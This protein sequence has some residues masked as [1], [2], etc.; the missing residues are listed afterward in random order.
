MTSNLTWRHTDGLVV[1]DLWVTPVGIASPQLPHIKEGLPVDE[2]HQ[3]VEVVLFENT[4]AQELRTHWKRKQTLWGRFLKRLV[5][6]TE[7]DRL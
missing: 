3:P 7:G 1:E 2:G 6:G 5:T 4:R